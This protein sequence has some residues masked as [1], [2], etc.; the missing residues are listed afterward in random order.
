M[1]EQTHKRKWPASKHPKLIIP[2]TLVSLVSLVSDKSRDTTL[3]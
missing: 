1:G 2:Y 3:L